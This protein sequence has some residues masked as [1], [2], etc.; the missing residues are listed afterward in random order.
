MAICVRRGG[1]TAKEATLSSVFSLDERVVG[2]VGL[3]DPN[4]GVLSAFSTYSLQRAT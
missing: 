4:S 2:S 3:G 1:K